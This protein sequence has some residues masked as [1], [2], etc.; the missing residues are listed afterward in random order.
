MALSG[1]G[2]RG[3]AHIGVLKVLSVAGYK[4]DLIAGTSMGAIIGAAYAGGYA[5]ETI[6]EL[7]IKFSRLKEIIKLLDIN[8]PRKGLLVGNRVKKYLE[9][10]FQEQHLFS[11]LSIPFG[12]NAV[13]LIS[14]R[15]IPFYSGE[16]LPAIMASISIPGIFAP[17]KLNGYYLV[18]GGLLNNLPVSI[19]R[20]MGADIVIA[21]NVETNPLNHNW[22]VQ[23]NQ[24]ANPISMPEFFYDFYRAASIIMAHTTQTN[25]IQTPPTLLIEPPI[26]A[27]VTIFKGFLQAQ[28]IIEYGEIAAQE[29]LPEIIRVTDSFVSTENQ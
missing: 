25:L 8:P 2:A 9:K 10:I 1:G 27:D 22:D 18:D 20:S 11:D 3:F 23:T 26:P 6:E 14:G 4:I 29:M 13:D 24:S 28:Q 5:P 17:V 15:E 16:L 12:L 21:I 19:A 7:A